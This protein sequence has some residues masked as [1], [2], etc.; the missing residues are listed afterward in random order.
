LAEDLYHFDLNKNR[1]KLFL[2]GGLK[3]RITNTTADIDES[4]IIF[5]EG[6]GVVTDIEVGP[7][8]SFLYT[9]SIRNGKIF[10]IVPAA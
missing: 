5:A 9:V 2:S 7:Y 8:D 4:E 1:T 10:R 3:D 6:F